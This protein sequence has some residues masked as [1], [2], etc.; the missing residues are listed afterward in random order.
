MVQ[1][2][3]FILQCAYETNSWIS[4]SAQLTMLAQA[5]KAC[6]AEAKN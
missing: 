3:L 5:V 4:A 2:A 6:F 1:E